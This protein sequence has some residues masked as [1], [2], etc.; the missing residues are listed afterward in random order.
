MEGP[1][2]VLAGVR[3]LRA[4][5]PSADMDQKGIFSL[6]TFQ[7]LSPFLVSDPTPPILFPLPMVTN[8]LTHASLSWHSPM[9]WYRTCIGPRAS[10]PIDVRQGHPLLHMQL[11]PWFHPFILFG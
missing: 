2:G 1:V 4:R 8:T 7:I 6:F 10:P 3:R 9:L 5:N 11:K